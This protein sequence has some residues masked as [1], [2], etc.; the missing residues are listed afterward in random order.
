[1]AGHVGYLPMGVRLKNGTTKVELFVSDLWL[2]T[3][4]AAAG[5]RLEGFPP[6]H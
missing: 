6:A 2:A 1:V 5:I 4:L 3:E